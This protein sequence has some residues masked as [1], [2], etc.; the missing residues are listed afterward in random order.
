MSEGGRGATAY[1]PSSLDVDLDAVAGNARAL[2]HIVGPDCLLYAALK[3]DAY[4]FGLVPVA[5]T[6]AAAGVD[7]LAVA[8]AR[9]AL[10]LRAAGVSLPILLYAGPVAGDA[11][12][13][14]VE[15]H[16]LT[17]TVTDLPSAEAYS[18]SVA[19]ELGVFVKVDVGHRRVG[20]EP[21]RLPEFVEAVAR[22]P[23]LRVDGIYTHLAVPPDPVPAGH[24]ER[25]FELFEAC[26]AEVAAAGLDVP[27][28]MAAS[29]SVL[30]LSDRMSLNAVDPGRLY[31]G[32]VPP[33]PVTGPDGFRPALRA[34][35]TR[36][37]QVK[38]VDDDPRRPPPLVAVEPGMRL[39]IIPLGA[40]DGLGRASAAEVLV[41]GRRAPLV[42]PVSLEHCRVDLSG[43][44]DAA[45]GD[46]VVV[47]GRQ[48][49]D[50]ITLEEVAAHRGLGGREHEVPIGIAGSVP[51]AYG[52]PA[53]A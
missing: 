27:V 17:P 32:T 8:R 40:G 10:E 21:R 51:R 15:E 4:G 14:A 6:L 12:A 29:S 25:Q 20:L 9:D 46:E 42:E 53:A 37:V 41:G 48:G 24:V 7:A 22:L 52:G 47:I 2:R 3:C 1:E 28:R 49:G 18:G 45:V 5:R 39:G 26:L 50:E 11:L 34:F 13:A 33:G 23:R 38:V 43:H 31:F 44:P 36:L 30:R 19:R 35:R 16:D